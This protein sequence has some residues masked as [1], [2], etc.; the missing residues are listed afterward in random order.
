MTVRAERTCPTRPFARDCAVYEQRGGGKFAGS[1][2][3]FRALWG[4]ICARD[5]DVSLAATRGGVR[6]RAEGPRVSERTVLLPAGFLRAAYA[7]VF[8]GAADPR[9]RRRKDLSQ[10]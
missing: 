5:A 4:T 2:R 6:P 9:R 8:R 7:A 1:A 10:A 3:A